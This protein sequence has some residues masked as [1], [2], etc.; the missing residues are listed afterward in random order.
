MLNFQTTLQPVRLLAN[1]GW[2]GLM[3][4]R[5]KGLGGSFKRTHDTILRKNVEH[6]VIVNSIYMY[7]ENPPTLFELYTHPVMQT[8]PIYILLKKKGFGH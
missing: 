6:K 1:G 8:L 4:K 5:G 2:S 3:Y 7:I